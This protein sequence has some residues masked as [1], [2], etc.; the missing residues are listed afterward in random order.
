M[1]NMTIQEI[2]DYLEEQNFIVDKS[3]KTNSPE[4]IKE[5]TKKYSYRLQAEMIKKGYSI[6]GKPI[7]KEDLDRMISL[8]EVIR[9]N[10]N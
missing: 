1:E 4:F 3:I 5:A 8:Y 2:A 10:K 6:L 7:T 9:K